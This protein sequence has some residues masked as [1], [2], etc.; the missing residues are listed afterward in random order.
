MINSFS[1][2]PKI[3]TERLILRQLL[4]TDVDEVFK[5]QSN[6][7][8][9]QYADMPIYKSIA[10]AKGFIDKMNVGVRENKWI[11]WAIDFGGQPVGTISLWNFNLDTNT[12]ELGYGLYNNRG[13]GLMTEAVNAVISYGFDVMKL[14][15]IKAFTNKENIKSMELLKRV[16]FTYECDF[17]EEH[18]SSGEP[19]QMVIYKMEVK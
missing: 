2:F 7:S 9:F 19:M 5:Y 11:K 1:K 15:T 17:L 16:G 18:T 10:E 12:A 8:N 3:K 13:I 4:Q 6:K 14:K